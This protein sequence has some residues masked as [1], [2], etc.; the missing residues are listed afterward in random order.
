MCAHTRFSICLGSTKAGA[1]SRSTC[2]HFYLLIYFCHTHTNK[3]Y[4]H[5]L[6]NDKQWANCDAKPIINKTKL[7]NKSNPVFW[8]LIN[9]LKPCTCFR[10]CTVRNSHIKLE[11]EWNSYIDSLMCSEDKD[12]KSDCFRQSMCVTHQLTFC[13]CAWL[14]FTASDYRSTLYCQELTENRFVTLWQCHLWQ[15]CMGYKS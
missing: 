4:E 14:L 13:Q 11:Y 10:L 5:I 6:G 7:T 12:T 2:T 3:L 1:K 15:G 8:L 9:Y